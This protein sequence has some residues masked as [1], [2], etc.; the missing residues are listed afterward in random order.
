MEIA[1]EDFHI[2]SVIQTGGDAHLL[3]SGPLEH[4]NLF[5]GRRP[6]RGGTGDRSFRLVWA[7][8]GVKVQRLDRNAQHVVA[9]RGCDR[10]IGGHPRLEQ[11]FGIGD[12]EHHVIG[13]DILNRD[14]RL[15]H[16]PHHAFEVPIREGVDPEARALTLAHVADIRFADVGID[17][18]L[19]QVL[20]DQKQRRGL[21]TGRDGLS[22]VDIARHHRAV[23]RRH[24]VGVVQAD[25]GLCQRRLPL[26]DRGPVESDLGLRHSIG[27][28][29]GVGGVLGDGVVAHQLDV[30]FI[31]KLF[32]GEVGAVLGQL[33]PVILHG[34]VRLIDLKL[35]GARVN[36]GDQLAC[37]DGRIEI[38]VDCLNRPGYVRPYLDRG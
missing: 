16:L 20:G 33:R 24:D 8:L 28:L 6:F 34:R 35:E 4:P 19:G 21:E 7:A 38:R 10:Y 31:G 22:D 23:H 18:H 27:T 36:L 3:K 5:P 14:W 1:A 17:L 30:A 29:R 25:F 32:V 12:V 11:Q 2:G 13:D 37:F 9:P 15:T 26:L